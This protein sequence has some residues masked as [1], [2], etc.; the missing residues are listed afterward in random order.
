MS[1]AGELYTLPSDIAQWELQTGSSNLIAHRLSRC[2]LM[3]VMGWYGFS[4]NFF[5]AYTDNAEEVQPVG[6]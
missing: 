2:P 5:N 3:V 4:S 6:A 1:I